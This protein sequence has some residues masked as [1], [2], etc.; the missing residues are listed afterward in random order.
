MP[1]LLNPVLDLLMLRGTVTETEPIAA[2]MRRLR[3]EGDA[4]A[5][6]EVRPGQQVRVLVGSGLTR[7]TYSVW[8]HEPAG[9]VEL[10]VLDHPEAGPGARWGRTA[11][12]GDEVRLGRP[13]GSFVLR[14]E[15]AHHVFVGE[16]TASVAFGAMLAA[17]PEQARISGCVETG[18]AADRLPLRHAG[19]LNWSLRGDTSLPEA[20]RRLA[21]EPGGIAYVAGEARTVQE[22]RRVLVREAGWDRRSVLTKPFWAPGKR[23]ME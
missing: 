3:I 4:L 19:R 12:V 13:E 17:L 15:A 8:R 6:L 21:P 22:V 5:G 11:G 23:G 20:V 9:A 1:A 10:C 2:R 7:R 18:T 16:E 14:A